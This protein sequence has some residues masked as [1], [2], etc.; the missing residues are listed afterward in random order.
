M[1]VF[2]ALIYFSHLSQTLWRQ[3]LEQTETIF[4]FLLFLLMQSI[5]TEGQEYALYLSL[6]SEGDVKVLAWLWEA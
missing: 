5:I 6:Q 3:W 4:A 1:I 2:F